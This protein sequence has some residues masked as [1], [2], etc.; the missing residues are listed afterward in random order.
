MNRSERGKPRSERAQQFLSK[1]LHHEN[2]QQRVT[3]ADTQ[4]QRPRRRAQTSV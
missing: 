4:S 3:W 1:V 2:P